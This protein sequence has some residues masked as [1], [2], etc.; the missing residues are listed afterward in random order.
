M[1]INF[2]QGSVTNPKTGAIKDIM[3]KAKW[4]NKIGDVLLGGGLILIGVHYLVSTAF[5]HG[6]ESFEKAELQ[7]LSDAGLLGNSNDTNN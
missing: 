6:A 5:V 3:V 4:P 2:K 7:A 1:I